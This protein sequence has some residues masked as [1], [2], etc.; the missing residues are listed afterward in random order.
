MEAAWPLNI[1]AFE[2]YLII[3]LIRIILGPHKFLKIPKKEVHSFQLF[4]IIVLDTT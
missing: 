3:H 1:S 4:A 2:N